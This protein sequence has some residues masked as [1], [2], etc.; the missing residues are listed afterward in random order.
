MGQMPK[1]LEIKP[2]KTTGVT[3]KDT[4]ME[5]CLCKAKFTSTEGYTGAWA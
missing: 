3:I 4:E 2:L 5:N 1:L